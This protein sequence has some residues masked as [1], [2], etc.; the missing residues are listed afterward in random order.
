[1][2]NTSI[3]IKRST[4]TGRPASLSAGE[5]AYSYQSNTLFMGSPAGT[6]VINVGGQYYTSTLDAATSANTA[7]TL[8]KRDSNN[9]FY[10]GLYG[11]ANTATA[12]LNSRNFSISGGDITASAVGFDGT[13]AVT[14]SA[15]LD[16]VTGL[17][18]GVYGGATAVPVVTVAANGRIMSIANTSISTSFTVS[19]NTGSGTQAGGGTLTVRGGGTGVTTTVTG[20]GG[21]ETIEINTDN[22]VVR[23]NTASLNQTIDGNITVSGNLTVLGSETIINVNTFEVSD[24]LIY[25]AGNNYTSDAV[26]IGFVANY[27]NGAANLHAGFIR[28]AG[29]KDFYVFDGYNIEPGNNVIDITGNGFR[30]ANVNAGTFKGNLIATTASVGTLTLSSALSVPNGGTGATTLGAGQILIGNGT[31]AVTAIANVGTAGAYGSQDYIPV[32]TTDAYG[33]VTAVSNTAIAIDASQI[34]RGTLGVARGGTGAAT[35]TN[36]SI[37]VGSGTDA[38]ATLAN[39]TYTATGSGGA[40]KTITSVTVDSYGRLTA[41]TFSSI[42]GLSVSQG[43]TGVS[44]FTT[45]GITFGNGTSAL[46][47]TAAAGT[48]DQTWSNQILTTTNAGVPVW[49][50]ALDGGQF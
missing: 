36:G 32:I 38:L 35:F 13:G 11:N 20:S 27:N 28:H 31:G 50:T 10:G 26:D 24:P 43:G 2:A 17:S 12:L 21:S 42:S 40:D 44:T 30:K 34:N 39:S 48:S 6:G 7:G 14:L 45:N 1:M 41:A 9:N 25:L 49:S 23:S 18:A 29:D 16:A 33:R 22:T 37:L 47:V 46:G 19:G 4:T 3:L 8:V 15:S 5:F